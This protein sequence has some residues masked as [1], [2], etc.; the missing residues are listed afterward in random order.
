MTEGRVPETLGGSHPS[1][2]KDVTAARKI[3][4]K[5]CAGNQGGT[6]SHPGPALR[7]LSLFCVLGKASLPAEAATGSRGHSPGR[8]PEPCRAAGVQLLTW[9]FARLSVQ[10]EVGKPGGPSL[11]RQRRSLC[12]DPGSRGQGRRARDRRRSQAQGEGQRV[13]L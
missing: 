6:R 3:E 9:D 7:A 2:I 8:A 10:R 5:I 12:A 1:A 11:C 13:T 4:Y